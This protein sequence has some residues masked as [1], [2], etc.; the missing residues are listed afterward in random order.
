MIEEKILE[1]IHK[2]IDGELTDRGRSLLGDYLSHHAEA[3]TLHR[4]LKKMSHALTQV[5]SEEPSANLKKGIMN[6]IALKRYAPQPKRFA[7]LFFP[8]LKFNFKYAYVF[9]Y[10]LAIG[11]ITTTAI[12]NLKPGVN[13]SDVSGSLVI[14]QATE[15]TSLI[16]KIDLNKSNISGTIAI[17]TAGALVMSE[18]NL[19][20]KN[21]VDV[22]L[23]FDPQHLAF[24]GLNDLQTERVQ[25]NVE[26]NYLRL[27]GDLVDCILAFQRK[28]DSESLLHVEVLQNS[29]SIADE[30]I[31]VGVS[32]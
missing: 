25:I 30:Q 6:A 15:Q 21:Q 2:E 22:R 18:I 1:M 20:S 13:T 26:S 28:T 5:P 8:G 7:Q 4:D 16:R 23:E 19:Q 17:K 12:V 14:N 27:S 11:I 24:Q 31:S 9:V 3:Q 10:G 29:G 32:K